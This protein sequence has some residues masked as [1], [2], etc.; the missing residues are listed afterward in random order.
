MGRSG[1]IVNAE[2]GLRV[3]SGPG[4]SYEILGSL[5]N[6]NPVQVIAASENGWYQI[7]YSGA[8][9]ATMYG[10]VLGDYISTD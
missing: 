3:R 8:G 2:G 7:S 9:G 6:G 5:V 1:T 4:T 10:Y